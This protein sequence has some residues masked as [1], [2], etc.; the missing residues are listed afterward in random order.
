ML[1]LSDF[2]RILGVVHSDLKYMND[3]LVARPT[4]EKNPLLSK[5]INTLYH[6]L[7]NPPKAPI[8]ADENGT[9]DC[10]MIDNEQTVLDETKMLEDVKPN[11]SALSIINGETST[12]GVESTSSENDSATATATGTSTFFENT[13]MRLSL[14]IPVEP[15][16]RLLM[17][18]VGDDFTHI[19]FPTWHKFLSLKRI[20]NALVMAKSSNK[21]IEM[22]QSINIP[23]V[24]VSSA[25]DNQIFVGP[26]GN[27]DRQNI[28]LFMRHNRHMVLAEDYHR[29]NGITYTRK[30]K[31][32]FPFTNFF[33]PA[34]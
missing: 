2:W 31:G 18:N 24:F 25:H 22:S 3:E 14:P 17:V 33:S 34:S 8:R 30:S 4:P 16:Q 10:I 6:L 5:K 1:R 9:M 12:T 7:T 28:A 32:N 23:K 21:V 26:Y 13:S 19:W 27:A 11:L 15:T 20:Q 29:K